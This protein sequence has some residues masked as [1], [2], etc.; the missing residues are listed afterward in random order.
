MKIQ[1]FI[2]INLDHQIDRIWNHLREKFLGMSVKY[3]ED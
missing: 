1:L 2:V 3:S